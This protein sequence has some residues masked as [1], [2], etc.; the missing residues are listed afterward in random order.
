MFGNI[1][2]PRSP[3]SRDL[4]LNCLLQMSSPF[5]PFKQNWYSPYSTC[6]VLSRANRWKEENMPER[7]NGKWKWHRNENK[8]AKYYLGQLFMRFKI[9]T[10]RLC[11]YGIG[12]TLFF[13]VQMS[14]RIS[15]KRKT[16]AWGLF[17]Y[18][19]INHFPS[20]PFSSLPKLNLMKRLSFKICHLLHIE[21]KAF[22]ERKWA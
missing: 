20:F 14:Q 7:R 4:I 10:S 11:T 21:W 9:S 6:H 19:L 15:A 5:S 1:V 2:S 22:Q 13:L 18:R 12:F 3:T 16:P 17:L 8:T